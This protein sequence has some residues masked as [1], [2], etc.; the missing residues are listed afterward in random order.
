MSK[1]L[2]QEQHGSDT[3]DS[4]ESV[5]TFSFKHRAL[6]MTVFVDHEN[7]SLIVNQYGQNYSALG[8]KEFQL[9]LLD[10]DVS[11][12]K[13]KEGLAEFIDAVLGIES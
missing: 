10:S 11:R 3:V 2:F 4:H 12:D 5:Y 8:G 7:V 6:G 1:P 13:L 9:E